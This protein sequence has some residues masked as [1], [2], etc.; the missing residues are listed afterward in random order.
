M[1]NSG[2]GMYDVLNGEKKG[3]PTVLRERTKI[4]KEKRV[5]GQTSAPGEM[6]GLGSGRW[7]EWGS[8]RQRSG[9]CQGLTFLT[10]AETCSQKKER[11]K[12]R[13][14]WLERREKKRT[15]SNEVIKRGI[16]LGGGLEPSNPRERKGEKQG[17]G[18]NELS[19]EQR[20]SVSIFLLILNEIG[21]KEIK[22][23]QGEKRTLNGPGGTKVQG[24]VQD[25]T[26]E[27]R[28]VKGM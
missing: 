2:K 3:R 9:R 7:G 23:E 18:G 26:R 28:G 21:L 16:H 19:E 8:G 27:K 6:G 13:I 4:L 12:E 14:N 17:E 5:Q 15:R 10:R 22:R 25:S 11:R 24:G 1:K 20:Y